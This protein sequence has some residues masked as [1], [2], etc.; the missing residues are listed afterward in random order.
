[1]GENHRAVPL[2]LIK[3]SKIGNF[4]PKIFIYI[5]ISYKVKSLLKYS[6]TVSKLCL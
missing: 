3:F 2:T 1:M 6:T 4:S 5:E